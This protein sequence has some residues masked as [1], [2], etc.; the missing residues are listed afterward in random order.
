MFVVLK[1][2]H[3]YALIIGAVGG[4]GTAVIMAKADGPPSGQVV[5]VLGLFR[6]FGIWGVLILWITGLA[7]AFQEHGTLALGPVFYVKL[8]A[9]AAMLVLILGSARI[10]AKARAAGTPPPGA[11]LARLGQLGALMAFVAVVC[12]VIVF[13]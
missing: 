3:I 1:V 6:K 2:I 7:M 13:K 11:L 8:L 4:M 10:A 9:A 5:S 12:A